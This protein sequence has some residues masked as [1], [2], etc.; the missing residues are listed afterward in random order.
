MRCY[1]NSVILLLAL[2]FA[3]LNFAGCSSSVVPQLG[4]SYAL[5]VVNLR[6]Q[7]STGNQYVLWVQMRGSSTWYSTALRSPQILEDSLDFSG[8]I[9]IPQTPDSIGDAYVSIEPSMIPASPT[10]IL[11]AGAFNATSGSASLSTMNAGGVGNFSQAQATATF[12][13]KSGDTTR[14]M[15][16]FY[17]MRFRNGAPEPSCANVPVAPKGWSYGLWV[18]DSNFL[19]LH[20]FFYGAFTNPDN[21]DT[22]PT[23]TDY[24]FPGGFNPA[25]LNDPGAML[26]VTLEPSFVVAGNN[27]KGPSP[28][29]ILSGQLFTFINFNDTLALQNSWTS[30]APSG[31]LTIH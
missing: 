25:P 5:H 4:D 31:I 7:D 6:P 18:V 11:I 3:G 22:N 1:G 28:L 12:T 15:N 2:S 17:L 26:E 20:Q 10:S 30:S 23:N 14:A 9:T 19:P 16:E 13:T 21:S 27:P 29:R 24:P 8:S